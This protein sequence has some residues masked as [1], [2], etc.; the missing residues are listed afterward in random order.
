MSF[1]TTP[2]AGD[3]T[4]HSFTVVHHSVSTALDASVPYVVVLVSL[5]AAPHLRVVGNLLDA[6]VED[7]SIGMAVEAVWLERITED[8]TKVLL[9]QWRRPQVDQ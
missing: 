2:L 8:G 5:D 7:V 3:G 6:P 1:S 9:P 4:V